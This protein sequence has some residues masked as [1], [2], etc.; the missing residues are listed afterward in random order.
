MDKT[1]WGEKGLFSLSFHI[2]VHHQQKSGPE[3]NQGRNLEAGADEKPISGVMLT[4][5]LA[6]LC[7]LTEQ[8]TTSLQRWPQPQ[9]PPITNQQ[10]V[11]EA[12]L[13]PT[14]WRHPLSWCFLFSGD[15]SL[16]EADIKLVSIIPLWFKCMPLFVFLSHLSKRK[17]TKFQGNCSHTSQTEQTTVHRTEFLGYSDLRQCPL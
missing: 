9:S 2:T 8:R 12:C 10:S 3:L 1:T 17:C 11:L 7:F 15:S 13:Q 16:C 14:F 4:R 5:L 6:W